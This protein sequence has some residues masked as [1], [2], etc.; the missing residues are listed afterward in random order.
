[1][2]GAFQLCLN[3]GRAWGG[4]FFPYF[5]HYTSANLTLNCIGFFSSQVTLLAHRIKSAKTP[6][7]F[8]HGLLFSL[9]S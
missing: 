4:I 5:E 3:Q 7:S 6:R 1:M 8:S 9:S 2:E